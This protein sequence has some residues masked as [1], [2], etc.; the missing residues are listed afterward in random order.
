MK[1]AVILLSGG[2]DSTT[3]LAIAKGQGFDLHALTV[4]YGQRHLFELQSAKN[5]ADSFGVKNHSILDIDLAQFGGSAL[6]DNIKVP[7]DQNNKEMKQ[8]PV[9]YVPARNMV[10][11]SLALARA[12]TLSSFDIYI[13]VN[14]LDFSGYPDC[15]PEFIDSFE[16]TANLATKTGIEKTGKFKIHTPLINFTKAEIIQRGQELGVDY[17]LTSSCYDPKENGNPCGHC[18]ACILR[19]KG[20]KDAG[21]PDP[22][23]YK[24]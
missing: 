15:R 2:L 3:C 11:L 1:R 12:E 17:G 24:D 20:F 7:K 23:D 8:I 9:T 4:N 13:G 5:I 16:R 14:A 19:L 10:L 18:D 22:L 21:M 6:T